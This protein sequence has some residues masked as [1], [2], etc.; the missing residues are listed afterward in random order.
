MRLTREL[1]L[2]RHQYHGEGR[3]LSARPNV[4]PAC[5]LQAVCSLATKQLR[6]KQRHFQIA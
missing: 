6:G 5:A 4:T 3:S 2:L 1:R